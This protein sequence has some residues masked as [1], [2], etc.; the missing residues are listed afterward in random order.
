MVAGRGPFGAL[1]GSAWG[2]LPGTFVS[3]V[4]SDAGLWLSPG[5]SLSGFGLARAL[6]F[7]SALGQLPAGER[8]SFPKRLAEFAG[9]AVTSGPS[10][11]WKRLSR[12]RD[13]SG[14]GW[15]GHT[16][17]FSLT[18]SRETVPFRESPRLAHGCL[19]ESLL[20]PAGSVA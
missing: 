12:S 18:Q 19:W 20:T 6:S 11:C 10:V 7:C 16:F 4:V 15:S 1:L 2:V 17:C 8:Q 13:L 5:A 9:G 14:R 3:A